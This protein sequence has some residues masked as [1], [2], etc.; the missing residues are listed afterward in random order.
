MQMRTE[1]R[2]ERPDRGGALD[3][4]SYDRASEKPGESR[5]VTGMQSDCR[6]APAERERASRATAEKRLSWAMAVTVKRRG[7]TQNHP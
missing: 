4:E 1:T 6:V 2:L 5:D 3:E 7:H